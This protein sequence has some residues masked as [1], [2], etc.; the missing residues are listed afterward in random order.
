MSNTLATHSST[1]CPLALIYRATTNST[2]IMG[3]LKPPADTGVVQ[4]LIVD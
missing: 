4:V 3:F 2:T 1:S